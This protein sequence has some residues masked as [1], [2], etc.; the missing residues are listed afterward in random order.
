MVYIEIFSEQWSLIEEFS[1]VKY[2][3]HLN[4]FQYLYWGEI[5]AWSAKKTIDICKGFVSSN[6]IF[7]LK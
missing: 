7:Q 3:Y 4:K 2:Y 5:P 6:W 1:L